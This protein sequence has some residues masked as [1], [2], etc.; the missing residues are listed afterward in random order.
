MKKIF[1]LLLFLTLCGHLFCQYP[2]FPQSQELIDIHGNV[3]DIDAYLASGKNV[4]IQ[5]FQTW[6]GPCWELYSSN[7]IIHI[8]EVFGP[9][10]EDDTIVLMLEMFDNMP[11]CETGLGVL[12]GNNCSWN[13]NNWIEN[14]PLPI[15]D[16][17]SMQSIFFSSTLNITEYPFLLAIHHS[18][19]YNT[20]SADQISLIIP[21]LNSIE[22]GSNCQGDLNTLSSTVEIST[23]F[24][25]Q[26]NDDTLPHNSIIQFTYSFNGE[27][28]CAGQGQWEGSYLEINVNGNDSIPGFKNGYFPDEAYN[29]Q[30]I[31]PDGCIITE[32]E[33]SYS[34]LSQ[35]S[36]DGLFH[37]DSKAKIIKIKAEKKIELFFE[38]IHHDTCNLNIASLLV[39][40]T[41]GVDPIYYQWSNSM[42]GQLIEGLPGN[43]LVQIQAL[44]ANNCMATE[45]VFIDSFPCPSIFCTGLVNGEISTISG[46]SPFSV[47]FIN[48]SQSDIPIKDLI[49]DF[50]NGTTIQGEDTTTHLYSQP[51]SYFATLTVSNGFLDDTSFFEIEVKESPQ[52]VNV[53]PNLLCPSSTITL[54]SELNDSETDIFWEDIDGNLIGTDISIIIN[55]V[56]SFIL[57]ATNIS[58]CTLIDTF[59]VYTN[60]INCE[61]DIVSISVG[62]DIS[63]S[64]I[65]NDLITTPNWKINNFQIFNI[66]PGV[67]I[68]SIFITMDGTQSISDSITGM[69]S[70]CEIDCPQNCDS[71]DFNIK[72]KYNATFDAPDVF[73]PNGDGLNDKLIWYNLVENQNIYPDASITII[74]RWGQTVFKEQNFKGQ[75]DGKYKGVVLPSGSYYYV[76]ILDKKEGEI[77]KGN[78]TLIGD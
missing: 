21:F 1:S 34:S 24:I 70:I 2:N 55:E 36:S 61:S 27:K 6:C 49:W 13:N 71:T 62:S 15:V 45:E 40:T 73:T 17:D 33:V 31:L 20:Y 53:N 30:I 43:Q 12:L 11:G 39:Q 65:Q 67:E 47:E 44:D 64:L 68:D 38:Q 37:A 75:W 48:M 77:L 28:Y 52:S 74:N 26:I 7:S 78:I 22:E 32:T 16:L 35:Y 25:Q 69:Y 59:E 66:A 14:N 8:N 18:R 23:D 60:L 72:F 51:G 46:C 56:G 42:I 41:D 5:F 50:G 57:N 9:N 10:G 3:H 54:N 29:V 58:N 19:T 4:A 76:L 63:Y